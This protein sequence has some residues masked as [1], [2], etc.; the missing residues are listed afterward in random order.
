[1]R[2]ADI[3][4]DVHRKRGLKEKI[5]VCRVCHDDFHAGRYDGKRLRQ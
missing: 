1:M 2:K 4:L 5:P 3:Y